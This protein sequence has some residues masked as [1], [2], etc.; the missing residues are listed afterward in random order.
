MNN[1]ITYINTLISNLFVRHGKSIFPTIAS[2]R[3]FAIPK[4]CYYAVIF[5]NWL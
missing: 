3:D 1:Q 5:F 4:A 2:E